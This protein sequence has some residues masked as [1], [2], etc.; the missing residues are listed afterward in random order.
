MLDTTIQKTEKEV[1]RLQA[2]LTLLKSLAMADFPLMYDER[3]TRIKCG[4][5]Y[6]DFKVWI[7]ADNIFDF[8]NIVVCQFKFIKTFFIRQGTVS[9]MPVSSDRYKRLDIDRIQ[10]K[11]PVN[12]YWLEQIES[13]INEVEQFMHSYVEYE[14]FTFQITGKLKKP[15]KFID[16][17]ERPISGTTRKE[18]DYQLP[19]S[20]PMTNVIRLRRISPYTCYPLYVFDESDFDE[21]DLLRAERLCHH[22]N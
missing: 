22:D 15:V 13:P 2:E 9:I 1:D 8:N 19:M 6:T 3:V 4:G 20:G 17:F 10:T 18:V 5:L 12:N 7:D 11:K 16:N 14:G 21:N